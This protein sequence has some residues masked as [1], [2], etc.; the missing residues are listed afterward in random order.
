V[1]GVRRVECE[2]RCCLE[3]CKKD[4]YCFRSAQNTYRQR[5]PRFLPIFPLRGLIHDALIDTA[6]LRRR[7]RLSGTRKRRVDQPFQYRRQLRHVARLMSDKGVNWVLVYVPTTGIFRC[8]FCDGR[9][10]APETAEEEPGVRKMAEG[11][12]SE[13]PQSRHGGHAPLNLR[14]AESRASPVQFAV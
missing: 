12:T 4:N 7:R 5:Q 2:C 1:E 11:R 8:L 10:A 6:D 3:T 9:P 13:I 14:I